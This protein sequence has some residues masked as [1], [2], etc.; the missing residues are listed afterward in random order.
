MRSDSDL[1]GQERHARACIEPEIVWRAVHLDGDDGR[2]E[3]TA[4]HGQGDRSK[5][6]ADPHRRHRGERTTPPLY[7][8]GRVVS[9]MAFDAVTSHPRER[10]PVRIP[11]QRHRQPDARASANVG[12]GRIVSQSPERH[13]GIPRFSSEQLLERE[14]EGEL[15]E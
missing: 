5:R 11:R 15:V 9:G 6:Y 13:S 10:H 1:V 8:R 7:G 12:V 2:A 14:R 4:T 3:H